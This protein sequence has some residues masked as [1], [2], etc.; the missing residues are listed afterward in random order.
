MNKADFRDKVWEIYWDIEKVMD[1][2][3][4]GLGSQSTNSKIFQIGKIH[5]R[6]FN[7]LQHESEE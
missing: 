5:Q 4:S 3:D 2:Y 1:T 7:L 6:M